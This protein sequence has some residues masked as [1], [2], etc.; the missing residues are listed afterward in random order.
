MISTVGAVRSRPL[1][2]DD[3]RLLDSEPEYPRERRAQPVSDLRRRPDRGRVAANIGDGAR[4]RQRGVTLARPEVGRGPRQRRGAERRIEFVRAPALDEDLL[5]L[6]DAVAKI[7]LE[8]VMPRQLVRLG[9]AGVELARRAHGR[10]LV[11][12]DDREEVPVSYDLDV[13]QMPDRRVVDRDERRAERRGPHDAAVAHAGYGEILDIDVASGALR[14]DVRP[15]RGLPDLLVGCRSRERRLRIDRHF[16]PSIRPGRHQP[17]DRNASSS[18]RRPDDAVGDREVCG[19]T[20]ELR[21]RPGQQLLPRRR[22]RLADRNTAARQPGAA[23][24]AAAVRTARR[25]AVDDGDAADRDAELLGRHL[26]HRDA[27][28]GADVHLA[29]VDRDCA[30]WGD[31]QEA[32][33]LR[34]VAR[35]LGVAG[36]RRLRPQALERPAEAEANQQAARRFQEVAPLHRCPVIVLAARC[37]ARRMRVWAP[38]RH[39]LPASASLI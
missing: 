19:R 28:A 4:R 16:Q 31:R 13:G 9:P 29:R 20:P 14:G 34:R 15:R 8:V 30:V 25:I 39:R 10:P 37:T 26:R 33:D 32:V 1:D 36:P 11:A 23:A 7:A 17:R 22:R 38:H 12:G 24:G 21:R 5:A 6:D 18:R 27:H 3:P 2:E 35:A